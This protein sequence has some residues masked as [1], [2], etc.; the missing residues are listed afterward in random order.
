MANDVLAHE[1][2]ALHIASR[3]TYGVPRI[4]AE[5]RRLGRRVNR[6]RIA[7]VMRERDIRGVT[8]R[9]RRSLTGADKKARSAP[10]LI[11]RDFHADTPG[12]KLVATCPPRG[13][14]LPRLLAGTWPPASLSL[15]DARPSPRFPCRGRPED[16]TRP[17]GTPPGCN[18]HSDRDGEYASAEFLGEIRALSLRQ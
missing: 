11:G 16:G 12:T 7:R 10:D 17:G 1:I 15:R 4:H 14:A 13:L 8:R 2:T 3:K 9:K 6:K 5:L 18:M